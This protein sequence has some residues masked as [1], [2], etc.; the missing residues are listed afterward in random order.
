MWSLRN[1]SWEKR[2]YWYERVLIETARFHRISLGKVEAAVALQPR[3]DHHLYSFEQNYFFEYALGSLFK[4]DSKKR[5]QLAAL[6]SLHLLAREL[7]LLPQQLIHR[8][9]QSQNILLFEQ[10]TWLIDFQGMRAGLAPYD[11]AS[12]LCDPYVTLSSIEQK[13]LL[14]FYQK[15]MH[16]HHFS[17]AYDVEKV[18]WQCA[19]QRLMQAL[20]AYGFLGLHRGKSHFLAHV[21]SALNRLRHALAQLDSE[22][23]L[24]E[25]TDFLE[26]LKTDQHSKKIL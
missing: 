1:E 10:R 5:E 9:L 16:Q 14:D 23:A 25:L 8:D 15:E 12:L 21:P 19:V 6:P 22:H 11:L 4:I 2:R 3:F 26:S 13:T 24:E 7:S 17:F 18:F 20:G